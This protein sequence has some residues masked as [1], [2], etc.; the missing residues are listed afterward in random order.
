MKL[1]R[2]MGITAKG[3]AGISNWCRQKI[4][5]CKYR[6]GLNAK[7]IQRH[8]HMAAEYWWAARDLN[9]HGIATTRF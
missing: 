4:Y 8:Y 7:S 2:A 6:G 5:L 3:L 1:Q 9:P